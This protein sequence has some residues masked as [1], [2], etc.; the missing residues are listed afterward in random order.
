VLGAV[1]ILK[2]GLLPEAVI[3]LPGR[4]CRF[5]HARHK[6][7]DDQLKTVHAAGENPC[8]KLRR[9]A[10]KSCDYWRKHRAKS[11]AKNKGFG[12]IEIWFNHQSFCRIRQA[13]LPPK[14]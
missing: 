5:T 13:S 9:K 11:T 2:E 4:A 1:A 10:L 14:A 8:W 3:C 12:E 6:V 7:D